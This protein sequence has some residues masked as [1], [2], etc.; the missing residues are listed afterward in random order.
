MLK[1]V[2]IALSFLFGILSIRHLRTF[3]VHEKE[4]F[5]KMV[6]VTLWGG[7]V[8]I[9]ISLFL[10]RVLQ[11][12]GINVSDGIPF[13]YFYVGFVEELGKLI[14]LFLCWPLILSEVIGHCV[15]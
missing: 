14:A 10:Y 8:S 12:S 3:D 15:G 4:P 9:F 1:L 2:L 11:D 6:V 5:L 7:L 13:S